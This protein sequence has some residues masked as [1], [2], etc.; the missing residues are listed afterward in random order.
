M[1][2]GE[3][4]TIK[5]LHRLDKGYD[6]KGREADESQE[7]S[8][9]KFIFQSGGIIQ[10]L[11]ELQTIDEIDSLTVEKKYKFFWEEMDSKNMRSLAPLTIGGLGHSEAKMADTIPL[12]DCARLTDKISE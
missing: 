9:K 7:I 6:K 11:S 5:Q 12:E 4:A 1:S 8:Q 10:S 3:M 2:I